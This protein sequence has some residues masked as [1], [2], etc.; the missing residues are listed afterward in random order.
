MVII[1]FFCHFEIINQPTHTHTHII[2]KQNTIPQRRA[3]RNIRS[4]ASSSSTNNDFGTSQWTLGTT[5]HSGPPALPRD[6]TNTQNDETEADRLRVKLW[7]ALRKNDQNEVENL[8][9]TKQSEP[10]QIHVGHPEHPPDA[11]LT[12]PWGGDK[13]VLL[14]RGMCVRSPKTRCNR[15][16][17]CPK[18][19]DECAMGKCSVDFPKTNC[20]NSPFCKARHLGACVFPPFR[21]CELETPPKPCLENIH[22][23]VVPNDTCGP[24]NKNGI[25]AC[26]KIACASDVDCEPYG[27]PCP[28]IFDSLKNKTCAGDR[29][30][31]CSVD[32]DCPGNTKPCDSDLGGRTCAMNAGRRCSLDEHCLPNDG[33]CQGPSYSG[34]SKT[35]A[36]DRSIRCQTDEECGLK[37]PCN[38]GKT[39][40]KD[41]SQKCFKDEHCLP[42]KGVCDSGRVCTLIFFLHISSL[43]LLHTHN[44]IYRFTGSPNSLQC[45]CRLSSRQGQ[46]WKTKQGIQDV[47][48]GSFNR[49][50]D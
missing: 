10:S 3:T 20:P 17:D 33:P 16:E 28:C 36:L 27:S 2:V 50:S 22:C 40:S 1:F 7:E 34:P 14:Y 32:E 29:S 31:F 35:C 39:C 15:D 43:H 47:C 25:C 49:M 38:D 4:E 41:R 24:A 12:V 5:D 11:N 6:S 48:K 23:K 46:M 45:G 13:R 26:K 19:G 21:T 44:Y 37:A 18:K 30:I 9:K 8:L 42:D